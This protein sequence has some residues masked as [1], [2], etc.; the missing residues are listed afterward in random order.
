MI[1]D[2]D[3]IENVREQIALLYLIKSK[4][5]HYLATFIRT[6]PLPRH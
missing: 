6:E 4:A 5:L 2:K 1:K 3:P